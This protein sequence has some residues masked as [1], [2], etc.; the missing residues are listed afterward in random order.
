[1]DAPIS[2]VDVDERI[3]QEVSVWAHTDDERPIPSEKL[4]TAHKAIPIPGNPVG[5]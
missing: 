5:R 2:N 4:V 1:M 3:R